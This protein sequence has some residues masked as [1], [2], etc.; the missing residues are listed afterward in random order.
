MRSVESSA[1]G[2]SGTSL[3]CWRPPRTAKTISRW[4][5]GTSRPCG[6]LRVPGNEENVKMD[7]EAIT[8]LAKHHKQ[9]FGRIVS[10]EM[11]I[12]EAGRKLALSRMHDDFHDME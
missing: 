5:S 1:T 11:Y 4:T 3:W 10:C 6:S 9:V 2:R 8:A 12:L 7:H